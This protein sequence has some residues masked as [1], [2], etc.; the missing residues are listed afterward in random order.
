MRIKNF[1]LGDYF[2]IVSLLYLTFT[3]NAE[4]I[5]APIVQPGAPGSPSKILS[6][7]EATAIANT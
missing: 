7:S 6:E 2:L 5:S 1:I 3:I 4:N